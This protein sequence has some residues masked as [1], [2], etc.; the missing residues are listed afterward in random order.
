MSDDVLSDI[1]LG[2]WSIAP[3]I[4]A[5]PVNYTSG[6]FYPTPQNIP[7]ISEIVA[8]AYTPQYSTPPFQQQAQSIFVDADI[9]A[10]IDRQKAAAAAEIAPTQTTSTTPGWFDSLSNVILATEGGLKVATGMKQV[11]NDF[12]NAWGIT[13]IPVVQNASASPINLQPL[14]DQLKNLASSTQG[15]VAAASNVSKSLGDQLKGL[16]NIGYA[17]TGNAAAGNAA[18]IIPGVTQGQLSTG[19]IAIGGILLLA[20]F[21]AN[22]RK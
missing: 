5:G 7:N 13:K 8:S 3:I 4:Q 9:Q 20:A 16:F 18:S 11:V 19:L 6:Q 12:T 17:T 1:G 21:F 22:R 14:Q 15:T 10:D 2:D